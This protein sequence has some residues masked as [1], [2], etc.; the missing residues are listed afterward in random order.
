MRYQTLEPT[1]TSKRYIALKNIAKVLKRSLTFV[2]ILLKNHIKHLARY[3]I[4]KEPEDNQ[5]DHMRQYRFCK[6]YQLSQDHLDYI[7]SEE[8]LNEQAAMSLEQIVC[9]INR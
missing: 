1:N 6:K 4:I 7:V 3:N 9:M 8:T 2:N 5:I